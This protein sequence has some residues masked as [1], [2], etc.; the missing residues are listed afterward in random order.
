MTNLFKIASVAINKGK[1]GV[2]NNGYLFHEYTF[3]KPIG[4]SQGGVPRKTV[5]VI[6]DPK[7]SNG[8]NAYVVTAY[9]VQ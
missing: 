1:H 7:R 3:K 5:R 9:P 8:Q 6:T 2:E 4:E